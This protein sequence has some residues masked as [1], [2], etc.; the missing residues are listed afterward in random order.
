MTSHAPDT[1]S[2]ELSLA[3]I[4]AGPAGLS[5]ALQAAR[6]LPTA[7]ITVFDARPADKDV[8]TD[9][10]TLALSQGTVQELHRMG[11]WDPI[12]ATGHTAPIRAVHVSQQQPT[13]LW[14]GR[15]CRKS[16][17]ARSPA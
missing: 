11:I 8:S 17:T 6:A 2:P 10:R 7:R 3:I 14:P 12:D 15:V 4:G 13:V 5:L 9:A 16:T 1:S